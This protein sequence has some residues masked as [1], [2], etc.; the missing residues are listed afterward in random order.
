MSRAEQG[1]DV[2]Q[3]TFGGALYQQGRGF[4]SALELLAI[5]RGELLLE[6][7]EKSSNRLLP[8]AGAAQYLRPGHDHAR[9]LLV[10][11][12]DVVPGVFAGTE[13]REAVRA[14][15]RGLEAPV[16]GRQRLPDKW[17]LR[18][19]Y[20]YPAEA[21]HYDAVERGKKVSVERYLFRGAGGLAHKILRKDPNE[22]RLEETRS[23]FRRLLADSGSAVGQLLKALAKHDQVPV[24]DDEGHALAFEDKVE[25]KSVSALQQP[26]N[27]PEYAHATP[28]MELLREGVH[29]LLV[30]PGISDFDRIEGVMHWVPWTV[31]MHQLT[32][33][34]RMIGTDELA[35]IVFDVGYASSPVRSLAR[36]HLG[37]ATAAIKQSL[38][39]G[40]LAAG[41]PELLR[42]SA[43][44]WTGPRSFFSTTMYAVGA[45]NSNAGKRH[46][47]LRPQLLQT[48]VH[49][50]VDEPV[51]LARFTG[52]ILGQRLRVICD[53]ESAD[54]F[55]FSEVEGR[56]LQTNGSHLAGRLDEVGMVRAF[57]DS[58]RMVG[59][60]E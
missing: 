21:I 18:H 12:S 14:L 52:E 9:R 53:R 58:T 26:P 25:E 23:E 29:R 7:E 33:A 54:Q 40:A 36:K 13:T 51:S 44:W 22:K 59:V 5:L 8:Q 50:L 47:E 1:R 37:D 48:I 17:Q 20:P 35:P 56:H 60:H 43:S 42:G 27:P 4:Y 55:E 30:R 19:F 34:R 49:A 45:L 11:D 32:M 6:A 24:K 15:L 38:H 31:A 3:R 46:F 39:K 10:A 2:V 41:L 16:P 28:W 57:S